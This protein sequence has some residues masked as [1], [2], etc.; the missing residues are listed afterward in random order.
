VEQELRSERLRFAKIRFE[1]SGSL[2][3]EYSMQSDPNSPPSSSSRSSPEIH[4][5]ASTSLETRIR[6][7]TVTAVVR[8][9]AG[10][11]SKPGPKTIRGVSSSTAMGL[12]Q[13]TVGLSIADLVAPNI[14]NIARVIGASANHR[15]SGISDAVGRNSIQNILQFPTSSPAVR[16]PSFWS[17]V[18]S[19]FQ[20]HRLG[21]NS[22]L[23]RGA[24]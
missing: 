19:T 2:S 23:D 22:R 5:T 14:S 7:V 8:S 6:P 3:S 12:T 15:S 21:S 13:S 24:R 17:L 18:E 10:P 20:N 9:P 4:E 16:L 1:R 11:T